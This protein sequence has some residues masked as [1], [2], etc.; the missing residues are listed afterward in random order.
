MTASA[1]RRT[2]DAVRLS[3]RVHAYRDGRNTERVYRAILA[4]VRAEAPRGAAAA[5]TTKGIR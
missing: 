3:A 2:D 4:G 1:C 5:P